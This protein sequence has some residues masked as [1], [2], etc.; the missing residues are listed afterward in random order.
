MRG[1]RSHGL[2]MDV[3]G[4]GG[5][6]FGITV[7]WEIKMRGI[8]G[9]G[10]TVYLVMAVVMALA[11]A[12]SL[13]RCGV[14]HGLHPQTADSWFNRMETGLLE[15]GKELGVNV[16]QQHRPPRMKLSRYGSSAMPSTKGRRDPG[17]S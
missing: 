3:S 9:K 4:C 13:L 17:G 16:Y 1:S 5:V 14:H 15:A 11:S 10:L 6:N 8:P 12:V 7:R 2:T